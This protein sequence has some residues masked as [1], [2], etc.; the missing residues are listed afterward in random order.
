I[1][2]FSRAGPIASVW[3]YYELA[4]AGQVIGLSYSPKDLVQFP[5]V[6]VPTLWFIWN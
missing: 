4:L 1:Y 2:W 3:I 6:C 5:R